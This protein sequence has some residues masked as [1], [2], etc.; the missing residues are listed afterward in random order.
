VTED[1]TPATAAADDLE[2]PTA[3]TPARTPAGKTADNSA[4]SPVAAE[5][6]LPVKPTPAKAKPGLLAAIRET[7][8]V[9]VIALGLSLLVKTFLVQAFYIPSGSMENTLQKDDRVVVSKLTPGPFDLKRGDIVVFEDFNGWLDRRESAN[10]GP[11]TKALQFVGL[12]ASKSNEHLIKRVIGLPGDR[13]QCCAKNGHLTI[14]GIEITEPYIF[15]GNPPSATDFDIVV[16]PGRVWVM[17]DHRSDSGDSRV[18]DEG[19]GG[20]VGSVPIDRITG[21]AFALVW[22]LSNA[23]WFGS[24]GDTFAAVEKAAK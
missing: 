5:S 16:P 21:K 22:P 11:V 19:S 6:I 15:A 10:P 7:V 14:N 8:V 17:G 4:E 13:V 18:H 1:T 2:V 3:G 12:A 20:K 23:T 24:P 9:V